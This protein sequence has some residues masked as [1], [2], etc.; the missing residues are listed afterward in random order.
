M[1]QDYISLDLETTERLEF[2]SHGQG[3]QMKYVIETQDQMFLELYPELWTQ[4]SWGPTAKVLRKLSTCLLQSNAGN[5]LI[6]RLYP[7]GL[8]AFHNTW[9]QAGKMPNQDCAFEENQC[10]QYTFACSRHKPKQTNAQA[11]KIHVHL[12]IQYFVHLQCNPKSHQNQMCIQQLIFFPKIPG[13]HTS[14]ASLCFS[15]LI[16]TSHLFHS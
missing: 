11:I 8:D 15:V 1:L 13:E 7:R 9:I 16:H 14:L 6:I 4:H 3:Y 2:E 5:T 10:I 12:I